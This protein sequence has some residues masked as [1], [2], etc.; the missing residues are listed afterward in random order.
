[1]TDWIHPNRHVRKLIGM[2]AVTVG[3]S[4]LGWLVFDWLAPAQHNPFKPLDLAT[5]P[6]IATSFKLDRLGQNPAAC[7]AVLDKVGV[8]YTHVQR[9][10]SQSECH[11]DNGLTLDES[12]TPYSATVSMSCP[13]AATLY[14]W[15]RHVVIPSAQKHFGV[16]VDRIETFGAY[17]C[18]RVNAAK[19]G[20]WSE[21]ATGDAIDISGFRLADGRT[22]LVKD[23]FGKNTVEGR[24][25]KEVRDRACDLFAVTLSP[26]YNTLHADHLHLDMGL[27][28]ICS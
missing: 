13:L 27:Y 11:L 9:E 23:H 3:L 6:G 10:G 24:F 19:T 18:R 20:A 2:A 28:A 12:L 21:H 16:T 22:I 5:K 25:L 4:W 14:V 7:F 17:S 1:M 8:A 26:D 15:E